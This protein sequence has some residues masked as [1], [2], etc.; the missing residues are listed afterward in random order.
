MDENNPE[1]AA[2][3]SELQQKTGIA[4]SIDAGNPAGEEETLRQLKKLVSGETRQAGKADLF[5]GILTDTLA[6]SDA[7]RE[8]KRLHIDETQPCRVWLVKVAPKDFVN[9]EYFLNTLFGSSLSSVLFPISRTELVYLAAARPKEKREDLTE[10]AETILNTLNTE[11]MANASVSFCVTAR[12]AADLAASYR[13]LSLAM[14][15]GSIFFASRR[16][17]VYD[18]LGIAR[19]IYELPLSICKNYLKEVYQGHEPLAYDEETFAVI[20][21][22]FDNGLNISE[23]ARKLYLHR[24]TLVY[25]LEKISKATGLDLRSFDDAVTFKIAVMIQDYVNYLEKQ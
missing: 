6:P 1:L 22:L 10:T 16:I 14:K 2:L 17:F 18:E 8:C 13:E 5:R 12:P 7:A 24:N 3:L 19:L 20:Q 21:A 23:A 11:A 15:I 9:A 25:R 4:F